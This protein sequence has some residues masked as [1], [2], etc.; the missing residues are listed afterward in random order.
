MVIIVTGLLL[1]YAA[2]MLLIAFVPM[3]YCLFVIYTQ[4]MTVLLLLYYMHTCQPDDMSYSVNY[5]PFLASH[6]TYQTGHEYQPQK[7][8][9]YKPTFHD[10][11][12]RH[13]EAMNLSAYQ[14]HGYHD[15]KPE[16]QK[17]KLVHGAQ[18]PE[19][20]ESNMMNAKDSEFKHRKWVSDLFSDQSPHRP[21][22][23]RV[24][25]GVDLQFRQPK[26]TIDPFNRDSYVREPKQEEPPGRNP[27]I[28]NLLLQRSLLYQS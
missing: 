12:T 20:L 9:H 23:N 2:S 16:A 13:E 18:E 28:N 24:L 4:Q 26:T 17:G 5:T 6:R 1:L 22:N 10:P 19:I 21:S 15:P 25:L 14:M 3:P 8:P 7:D 27:Q 11:Y